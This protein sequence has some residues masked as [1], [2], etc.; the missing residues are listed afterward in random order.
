MKKLYDQQYELSAKFHP[1][2]CF[3]TLLIL[4]SSL[5][6]LSTILLVASSDKKVRAISRLKSI[7]SAQFNP[8]IHD[9]I[10]SANLGLNEA[11]RNSCDRNK[12]SKNNKFP[13][14]SRAITFRPTL[15]ILLSISYWF[16]YWF[17]SG[18]LLLTCLI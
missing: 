9:N 18:M 10:L 12:F 15:L 7:L 16:R 2:C 14:I 4:S 13:R 6:S 8:L 3:P 1:V 11:L 5:A 17:F